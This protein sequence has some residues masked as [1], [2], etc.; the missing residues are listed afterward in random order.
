M[1]D[2]CTHVCECNDGR[3]KCTQLQCDDNAECVVA[4]GVRACKCSDGFIGNGITCE[5]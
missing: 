2:D 1:K 3:V 5:G 4:D